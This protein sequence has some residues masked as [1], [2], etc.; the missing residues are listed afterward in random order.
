M[1]KKNAL[2]FISFV[3]AFVVPDVVFSANEAVS[4]LNAFAGRGGAQLSSAQDPR[5]IVARIILFA[6]TLVGT[7]FFAY[8]VY[9]GYLWMT[10]AG[11][12][13]KLEK[14]KS[15]IRT[16]V[17]GALITLSAYAITQ[18]VS[19]SLLEAQDTRNVR[20]QGTTNET[21]RPPSVPGDAF[22]PTQPPDFQGVAP[23]PLGGNYDYRF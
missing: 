6:L 1:S 10:A 12:E 7:L 2:I 8:I 22:G 9:A 15:T 18:F 17:I 11:D 13:E 23:P 16:A 21:N 14:S 20:I 4:Q 19:T 3:V 5:I